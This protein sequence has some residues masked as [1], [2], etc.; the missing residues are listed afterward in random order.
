MKYLIVSDIHGSVNSCEFI[1]DEYKNGKYDQILCLGDVL[2]HGPRNDLPENYYPK[3]CIE[4]LNKLSND[5]ITV[6]G[7]CEAEV[8]QM[9]LNFKIH[10]YYDFKFNNLNIHLE[11]GHHLDLYNGKP[12]IIMSG[13]THIPVLEEKDG[14]IYLN[15]GSITIPKGGFPRSYATMDENEIVVYDLD[16]N[17]VFRR[18]F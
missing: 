6:K 8:D 10:D 14:I 15:P 16:K 7:N 18:N 11:H 9:V 12:N 3:G 5:I 13:H 4:I 17:V 2:Y 1:Y